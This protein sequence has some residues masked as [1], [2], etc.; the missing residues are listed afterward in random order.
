LPHA[1]VL[2]A[3]GISG[4]LGKLSSKPPVFNYQKGIDFIQQYWI[5]ST[6]SA[7]KDF[8]YRQNVPLEQGIKDTI[9][10]YKE[11]KWL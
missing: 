11:M 8:G 1:I 7:T 5:C 4:L 6:K 2:L 10:W 9:E 3:G